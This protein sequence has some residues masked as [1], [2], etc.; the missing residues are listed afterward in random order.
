MTRNKIIT[1][2]FS[3]L[4]LFSSAGCQVIPAVL[5]KMFPKQKVPPKFVLPRD[6]VLLVF[7]DDLQ[8]PVTYPPIKR[9]MAEKIVATLIERKAISKAVD[10]DEL[11]KLES[12]RDDFN[13]LSTPKIARLVGAQVVIYISIDRFSLKD[14]PIDTLWRG[15]LSGRVKVVD[16]EKGQIWPDETGG[17]PI[18]IVE[19]PTDNA[20]ESYGVELANKLADDLAEK[21][22]DLFSFHYVL[23][24]RMRE[25]QGIGTSGR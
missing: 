13:L 22:C 10:Y 6:K 5:E 3:S 4:L 2:I 23:R 17:F 24:S 14:N 15:T 11:L 8:N 16:V 25:K 19:P 20:Y 12:N 18:E 21:V 9:R 7:P 1:V